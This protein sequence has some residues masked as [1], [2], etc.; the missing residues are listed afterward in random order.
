M[1]EIN[2][3]LNCNGL[4]YGTYKIFD[5]FWLINVDG[6]QNIGQKRILLR[7]RSFLSI[8]IHLKKFG[9]MGAVH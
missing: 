9:P 2:G 4:K 7:T 1:A 5:T 8:V 3:I 6:D